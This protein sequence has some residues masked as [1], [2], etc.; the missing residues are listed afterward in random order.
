MSRADLRRYNVMAAGCAVL[1]LLL[2]SVAPS[3]LGSVPRRSIGATDAPGCALQPPVAVPATIGQKS[4]LARADALVGV[5]IGPSPFRPTPAPAQVSAPDSEP[6]PV[7]AQ[8]PLIPVPDLTIRGIMRQGDG[9]ARALIAGKLRAVGD[10]AAP[11]WTIAAID[12]QAR[13]VTIE[14]NDGQSHTIAL[15]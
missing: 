7:P 6:A 2:V 3:L 15:K 11:G 14:S 10:E 12:A 9:S 5:P 4:A 8:R 13:S 1:P